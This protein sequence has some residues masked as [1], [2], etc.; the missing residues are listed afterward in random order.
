MKN[1]R[2]SEYFPYPLYIYIYIYLVDLPLVV[3]AAVTID[4][5]VAQLW[6]GHKNGGDKSDFT[7]NLWIPPSITKLIDNELWLPGK[8]GRLVTQ[9]L[10]L[11]VLRPLFQIASS[12]IAYPSTAAAILR[13]GMADA[14]L[15]F[16][17]GVEIPKRRCF[18]TLLRSVIRNTHVT[19]LRRFAA[20][21]RVTSVSRR[22]Y[23][24]ILCLIDRV[25]NKSHN[26]T[27]VST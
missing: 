6:L 19:W 9:S 12:R 1:L 16:R 18:E 22:A 26:C 11:R 17:H 10:T 20:S 2:G 23:L 13:L 8:T 25:G 15:T 5:Q 3:V 4:W 14:K 27:S 24:P 7:W 21:G